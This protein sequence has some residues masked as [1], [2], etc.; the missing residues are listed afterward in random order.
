MTIFR[1]VVCD[2]TLRYLV[3][4]CLEKCVPDTKQ[5]LDSYGQVGV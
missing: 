1:S 2:D 5:E 4:E 3:D